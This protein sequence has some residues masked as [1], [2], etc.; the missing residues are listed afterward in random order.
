M[1]KT[2]RIGVDCAGCASKMEA[3]CSKLDGVRSVNVNFMT[4]KI[5]IDFEDGASIPD[6]LKSILKA[7]RRID[8]HC[9]IH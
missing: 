1:K 4:Q 6:V 5:A 9:E 3:A 2:F 7:C 8:R